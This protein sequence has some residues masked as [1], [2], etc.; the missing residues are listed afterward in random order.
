[1][2]FVNLRLDDGR[3][4][5]S[6]RLATIF[7]E[8]LAREKDWLFRDTARGGGSGSFGWAMVEAALRRAAR[9]EPARLTAAI[10]R[11]ALV[12]TA[13]FVATRFVAARFSA[14]RRSIFGRRKVATAY[15]RA[16]PLRASTAMASATTAPAAAATSVSAAIT[17]TIT[18]ATV[19]LAAAIATTGG[20]RRVILSGVVVGRKI[21][22]SRGVRFGLALF[23][24]VMGVVTFIVNFGDVSVG[25]FAFCNGLFDDSGM[26]LVGE[27]VVVQGF[28]FG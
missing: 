21:L 18:A 9:F 10:F 20:A 28:V 7:G 25:D 23:G 13:I 22:G 14:L 2:W 5:G 11:A 15:V 6:E 19:V 17:A 8:R 27:G 24:G 3:R 12:T 16:L 4:R 26:L 1:L